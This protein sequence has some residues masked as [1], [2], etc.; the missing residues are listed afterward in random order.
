[1][2][3]ARFATRLIGLLST[4]ILARVLMPEDFGLV[5]MAT[6]VV[7]VIELLRAF[8]FDTVLIQK[9]QAGPE[10]YDTAWTFN[11]VV[12][13]TAAV[14]VILLSWPASAYYGDG[15]IVP[16][17]MILAGGLAVQGFENVGIVDFRKFMQF[18]KDFRFSLGAKVAGFLVTVPI[19]ILYQT[20]WAL[21]FG[22]IAT[23]VWAVAASYAMHP[24]RPR[25][26]FAASREL[27]NFSQWLLFNNVLLYLKSRASDFVIGRMSGARPLGL[28][29][30]SYEIAN[31]PT[32]EIVMPIN[33]A[34]YSGYAQMGSDPA[35]LRQGFLNV[36]TVIAAFALPAAAGIGATAALL[37]PLALGDRWLDAI[38][39]IEVLAIY[40]VFIALQTNTLYIYIALGEPRTATLLN[41]LHVAILIPALALGAS[42]AGALGAAWACLV[43]AI[44]N[45][46]VN[47]LVLMKRLALRPVDLVLASWRPVVAAAFMY[48]VVTTFMRWSAASGN[49]LT[50]ALGA[51]IELGLAAM[52]VRSLMA[53][54]SG[55]SGSRRGGRRASSGK[56][57]AGCRHPGRRG[58]G[59]EP[60][61]GPGSIA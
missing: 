55:C 1:M 15:R 35:A 41:A 45:A 11:V 2:V 42:Q 37:V 7:A 18:D 26:S 47:A 36:I 4:L 59:H 17:M 38:P 31:L 6:S 61:S 10:H 33:R 24:Y 13:L 54:R 3:L 40:G 25:L 32:T 49:A 52:L 48:L 21:V 30:V 16:I 50:D 51:A 9:Q 60:R 56:S 22:I 20:Y 19:A 29:T 23:R 46:P 5:A 57:C 39:L 44:V 43:T 28:F 27:M 53:E 14:V 8:G 34:V 58:S 12:G